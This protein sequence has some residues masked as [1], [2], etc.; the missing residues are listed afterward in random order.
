MGYQKGE[1]L[2]R[3][4]RLLPSGLVATTSWLND[5]G[6]SSALLSK[7]VSNG[8]LEQPARGV[9]R[10]P[11]G[12]LLWQH[13][14]ISLQTLL[15]TPVF[16]GGRTALEEQGLSHYVSATSP[17]EIHLYSSRPYPNWIKKIQLEETVVLHSTRRL[18]RRPVE[19]V[20]ATWNSEQQAFIAPDNETPDDLKLRSWGAWQWPLIVSTPERA[21]LEL[22]DE[23]PTRESFHQA[24]MLV[25]GLRTLSPRRMQR[26][27]EECRNIK[28]KRLLLWFAERHQLRWFRELNLE[29]IDLGAGKRSLVPNGKLDTKYQITVPRDM[30]GDQ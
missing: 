7:Y 18:S 20:G 4:Q 28:A 8:W 3:L 6:Y 22:L 24:D 29:N 23:V 14:V 10:R 1:K 21:V 13:A 2:N 9:Y 12:S 17:R 16:V 19:F 5:H 15:R 11:S 25:E 26:L 27:L 30:Y